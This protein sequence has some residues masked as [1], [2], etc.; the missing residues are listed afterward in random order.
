MNHRFAALIVFAVTAC[1]VD[2]P[3]SMESHPQQF[4]GSW[5]FGH[6][7]GTWGDTITWN[8]DGSM[9]GSIGHPIPGDARWGVRA[10]DDGTQTIC[11][12]GGNQSNCQPF[13]VVGDTLL[14]GVGSDMDRFRIVSRPR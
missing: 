5:V 11:V 4:I 12:S 9:R 13:S 14:W 7:D 6:S 8:A 1:S 2:H 10:R 3:R